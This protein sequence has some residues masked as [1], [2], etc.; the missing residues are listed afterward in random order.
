MQAQPSRMPNPLY[1]KS[2][3]LA[4]N[5]ATADHPDDSQVLAGS[6]KERGVG[7]AR[8]ARPEAAPARSNLL[9]AH[10]LHPAL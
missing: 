1:D 3:W 4:R 7:R 2:A 9:R 8:P 6:T 10:P 5:V